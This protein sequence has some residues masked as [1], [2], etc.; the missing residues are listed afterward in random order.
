MKKNLSKSCERKA[1]ICSTLSK[2][3]NHPTHHLGCVI[4]KSG[5]IL[6]S[7]Y[8]RVNQH[9]SNRYR[10][11]VD[12]V[13]AEQDAIYPLISNPTVLF[14]ASLYITRVN[15]NGH[16]LMARPCVFCMRLIRAVGIK[17]VFYSGPDGSI[18]CEKVSND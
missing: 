12:S 14:G 15:R 16:L 5:R 11:F 2:N 8:N 17:K 7:G 10:K 18:I 6:S 13:H 9:N 1:S 3:S 4:V